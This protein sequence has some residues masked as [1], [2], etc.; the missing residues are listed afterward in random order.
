MSAAS[1]A[2]SV[3]AITALVDQH[4]PQVHEGSGR[5]V[6]ESVA[7]R[8]VEVRMRQDPR[9][10]RPGGTVA[11]PAMFKLADFAV[12]VA[13][14]AMLGPAAIEAVTTSLTIT[15]LT[16]PAPADMIAKVRL[17][18]LGR[19]LAVGEVEL[20]SDGQPDMVAHAMATYALPGEP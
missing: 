12:Y 15:F 3:E 11:G 10:I 4:F 7:P 17:I 2:C 14:L 6:I 5:L 16:R 8:A 13:I 20:Y 1:T 19:R 9:M 18:K